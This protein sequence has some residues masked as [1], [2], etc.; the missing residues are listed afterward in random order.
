[1]GL[2]YRHAWGVMRSWEEMLGRA[3]LDMERG[4]GASLTLFGERMLRA[5]MRLRE[6]IDP[7]LHQAMG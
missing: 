5:E 2:S 4:R 1:M 7:A 3:L 6:Q